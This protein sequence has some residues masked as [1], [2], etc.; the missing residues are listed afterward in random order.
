MQVE[1]YNP[2]PHWEATMSGSSGVTDGA[3]RATMSALHTA[4]IELS[5]LERTITQ[6]QTAD[7]S[8]T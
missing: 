3:I 5:V 2:A 6:P 8:D 1:V 4:D 7:R